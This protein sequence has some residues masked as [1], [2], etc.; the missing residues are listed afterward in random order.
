MVKVY[1]PK[2]LIPPP[3]QATVIYLGQ[4]SLPTSCGLP[5]TNSWRATTSLLLDLAPRGGYLAAPI[6]KRVG[7]LLP[8]LFTLT[9]AR[10]TGNLFLCGPYPSVTRP[11][12]YPARHPLERGLS[13][14]TLCAPATAQPSLA[15]NPILYAYTL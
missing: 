5:G 8:H 9:H 2:R 15:S 4:A 11:G 13:S 14:G 12:R 1:T 6:T 10:R 3:L 7:A